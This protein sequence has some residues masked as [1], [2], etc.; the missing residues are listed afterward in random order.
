MGYAANGKCPA[1]NVRHFCVGCFLMH[2]LYVFEEKHLVLYKYP[3]FLV[4]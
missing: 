1:E 2:G 3:D 4:I